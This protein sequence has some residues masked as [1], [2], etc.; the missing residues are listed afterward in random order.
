MYIPSG[1]G[2]GVNKKR[3][4]KTV[5]ICVYMLSLYRGSSGIPESMLNLPNGGHAVTQQMTPMPLIHK[6]TQ[7][8]LRARTGERHGNRWRI[9][10]IPE[11]LRNAVSRV[12]FSTRDT[13]ITGPLTHQN[14]V[15]AFLRGLRACGAID[16]N[17]LWCIPGRCDDV[18]RMGV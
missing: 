8:P 1:V 3:K 13:D 7:R 18:Q 10:E 4:K 11:M 2:G 12:I 6:C 17:G 14:G 16:L 5:R 9:S 15:F